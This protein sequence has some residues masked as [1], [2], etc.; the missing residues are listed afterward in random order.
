MDHK[1][2]YER[3]YVCGFQVQLICRSVG[4]YQ[5]SVRARFDVELV[6]EYCPKS[7]MQGKGKGHPITGHQGPR[8]G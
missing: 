5:C 3:L 6:S 1:H 7:N 4:V 8:G 2:L